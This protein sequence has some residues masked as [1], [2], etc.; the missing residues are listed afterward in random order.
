MLWVE[1]VADDDLSC[2][3]CSALLKMVCVGNLLVIM[4]G[5]TRFL[6]AVGHL[7]FKS[8]R[9]AVESFEDDLFVERIL[10]GSCRWINKTEKQEG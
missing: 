9:I 7:A 2:S 5:P 8:K 4:A 10:R 3:V 6:R 1:S